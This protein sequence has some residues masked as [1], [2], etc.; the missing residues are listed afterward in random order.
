MAET[1]L[2]LELAVNQVWA[3]DQPHMKRIEAILRK[4][5]L[6]SDTEVKLVFGF[7]KEKDESLYSLSADG[8][9]VIPIRGTIGKRDSWYNGTSCDRI[10]AALV[11]A[12]DDP[13]CKQCVL[14]IDSPGGSSDGMA[15]LSAYIRSCRGK[16]PMTAFANGSMCSGAYWL[17]SA[18]DRVV[19][20]QDAAVGS[21]G[22]YTIMEDWSKA[23][24]EGGVKV[25]MI[26]AGKYKGE[27]HH[28][29][30]ISAEAK[31][32]ASSRV[33]TIA[34]AFI[35]DV[36]KN[37]NLGASEAIKLGD[38]WVYVGK[39]AVTAGLCDEVGTLETCYPRSEDPFMATQQNLPTPVQAPAAPAPLTLDGM[40]AL[41]A[42]MLPAAVNAAVDAAVEKKVG[43][44]ITSLE[45]KLADTNKETLAAKTEVEKLKADATA[46]LNMAAK[47][48]AVD[49]AL[50]QHR[51]RIPVRKIEA[52]RPGGTLRD[53]FLLMDNKVKNRPIPDGKGGVVQGTE[54]ERAIYNLSQEPV[55][56]NFE[57]LKSERR[58]ATPEN[59]GSV[60]GCLNV[61]KNFAEQ[62]PDVAAGLSSL[63]SGPDEKKIEKWLAD[64]GKDFFASMTE[65]K[66][67]QT[68]APFASKL[69]A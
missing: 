69:A 39:D 34:T 6:V 2:L 14:D 47:A 36:G 61:M 52:T 19:C 15:D 9:A 25:E 62:F 46:S 65:E 63:R 50:A 54:L 11:Q 55:V 35:D 40:R 5:G 44:V 43:S 48:L 26:K 23:L 38:G 66:R 45:T 30:P 21:I 16:K 29:F 56:S 57:K 32:M 27:G 24:E 41:L 68:I 31:E 12:M 10:K 33:D 53:E 67:L 42:E 64:Y 59:D 20:S 3:I 58:K 37:R 17:G 13:E 51:D 49:S 28:L 18:C 8:T 4:G 7:P 1:S 22:C 60:E